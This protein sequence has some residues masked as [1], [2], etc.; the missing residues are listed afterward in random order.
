MHPAGRWL[1]RRLPLGL[2]CLGLVLLL[3]PAWAGQE[4]LRYVG[5]QA[6]RECHEE[7]YA[8]YQKNAKKAHSWESVALMA[9]KLKPQ[10]L[11]RCYQ[12]HTTGYGRPGGFVSLQETPHQKNLGCECCHGPGSRHVE[13]EDAA[14]IKGK[15]K[16]ADCL[17]CHNQER[18]GAFHFRPLIYGGG[19]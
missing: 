16:I 13:S 10:E 18:V 6:C 12:C 4:G 5:S 8:S 3:C 9:P 14:D 15:L 1:C 17:G 19:H 11:R 7:Q 2:V